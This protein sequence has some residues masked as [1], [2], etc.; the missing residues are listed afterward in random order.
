MAASVKIEF[1]D[2]SRVISQT[3]EEAAGVVDAGGSS[4]A[5]EK[6][7]TSCSIDEFYEVIIDHVE[8]LDRPGAFRT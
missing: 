2:G 5:G 7:P 1:D 6:R 8:P 4:G 3:L